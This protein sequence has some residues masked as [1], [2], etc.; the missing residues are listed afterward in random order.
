MRLI[1]AIILALLPVWAATQAGAQAAATLV[2]DSVFVPAGGQQ[3]VAE[4]NVEVFFDGTRLTAQRI[5]FDQAAARLTIEGPVFIVAPDGTILTATQASLDPK[6]ENGILRGARLVLADQ[7]Q[8]AAN[9]I[10]RVDGRY[11]QLTRVAVTSCHICTENETPLWEIRAQRVIHDQ[12]ERQLYFDN[13]TFRVAGVPIFWF[14]RVRLP[15]PTLERTTGFMIP[16][17]ASTDSLGFG[18]KIPYFIRLGDHRDL[19][20]T[21]YLATS[22]T[23]IEAAYRQAF[24]RGDIVVDAAFTNDDLTTDNRGY[25]FADGIFNLGDEVKLRFDL[26]YTSEDTYLLEYGYSGKD[27]LDSEI[28][29]ERVRDRDLTQASLTY[30]T[31]LRDGEVSETL[32]PLLAELSWERRFSR[33]GG[34]VTLT[35]DLQSHYRETGADV[36]GRDVARI[37][38][39]SAWR[40][41]YI[42][43]FGLV[44][45]GTVGFDLDYYNVGD[46]TVLDDSLR[47]TVFAQ[48]TLRYPLIRSG[49]QATHVIEP[50]VQ[51]AWSDVRGDSVRNED[52]NST[53]F[54]EANLLALSRFAGE[55]AVETGLRGAAGVTW[56]RLDASA[57]DSTLTAGRVF[58]ETADT[59]FSTTSGLSAETSDWLIAGQLRTNAGFGVDSRVVLDG[60]FSVTKSE[61][62]AGWSG[63]KLDL[64]ASY[65]FLPED[66]AETRSADVSE[67]TIDAGYRF[68]ETWSMGFDARYD[69]VADSPT[70]TGLEIG[71][72]NECV[73]IDFSVSRRF[74][75]STTLTPSTNFGLS[76]GLNGFSAGRSVGIPS[77][78]CTD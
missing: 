37:G 19:T 35:S 66:A 67:W 45:D 18:V 74:T 62:R 48:T 22:T 72:K 28:A 53:E 12:D 40:G 15:D 6:L 77:H 2:A 10:D 31:S 32:P 78:R 57:W 75:S 33:L 5:V 23:T 63:G 39:G 26:E 3:L 30:L 13:A 38:L 60:G 11:T 42:T 16:R 21:P 47:S 49:A 43:T 61:T 69:V 20:I 46:D 64:T 70:Q 44:A 54:D 7:L 56:T 29:L 4:G 58:R 17:V 34:T 73:T 27:R 25:V 52:S 9:R 55:D 68:D 1:A 65:I 8:L 50:M 59:G 76:I 24:L 51:L 36:T 71:W 14:P 41:D